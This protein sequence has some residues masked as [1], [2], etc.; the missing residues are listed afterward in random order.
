M[1]MK[2]N[3]HYDTGGISFI[4]VIEAKLTPEQLRGYLLGSCIKYALRM[5]FKG[6]DASDAAKMAEY[7][8]WLDAWFS[9]HADDM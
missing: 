2:N 9:K 4:D 6:Q 3:L 1:K 7:S 5:N 8:K